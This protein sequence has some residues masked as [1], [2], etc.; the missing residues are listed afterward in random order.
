MLVKIKADSRRGGLNSA[1]V[2][3]NPEQ[4]LLITYLRRLNPDPLPP[5]TA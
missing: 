5:T 2:K 1:V 4:V 3:Q